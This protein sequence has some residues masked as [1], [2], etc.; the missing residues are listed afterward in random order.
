MGASGLNGEKPPPL[1]PEERKQVKKKRT[2]KREKRPHEMKVRL[3]EGEKAELDYRAELAGMPPAVWLR[4]RIGKAAIPNVE[5]MR[6]Q[7]A[8]INR[9]NANFNMIS[10]W[11]NTYKSDVEAMEVKAELIALKRLIQFELENGE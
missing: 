10:K 8:M 3:S 4:Y 6:E 5:A 1:P 11:V 7:T 9:W 2:Q